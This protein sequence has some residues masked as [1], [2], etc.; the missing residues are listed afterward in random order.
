MERGKEEEMFGREIEK[1][2]KK[3]RRNGEEMKGYC[4]NLFNIKRYIPKA[5][6]LAYLL[7]T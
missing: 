2:K 4:F 7:S 3:G 6:I 1:G 5:D